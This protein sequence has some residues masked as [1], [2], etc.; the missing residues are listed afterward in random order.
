MIKFVYKDCLCD[1]S[2]VDLTDETYFKEGTLYL[3]VSDKIIFENIK[4]EN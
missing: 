4:G 1:R 2:Y 3:E